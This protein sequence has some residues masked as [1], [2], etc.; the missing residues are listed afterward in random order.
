MML[1]AL[2]NGSVVHKMNANDFL[3]M[4]VT[5]MEHGFSE[6]AAHNYIRFLHEGIQKA[7]VALQDQ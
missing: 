4:E 3:D 7:E 1:I 5:I 2:S 6:P